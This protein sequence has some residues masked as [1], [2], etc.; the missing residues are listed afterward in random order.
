[1]AFYLFGR[2]PRFEEGAH[3][4]SR[5]PRRDL[6]GQEEGHARLVQ[7]VETRHGGEVGLLIV[8]SPS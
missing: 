4:R 8:N 6:R 3:R 5:A 1:M 7:T 2:E